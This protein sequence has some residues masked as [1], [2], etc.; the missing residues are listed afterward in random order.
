M[1]GQVVDAKV[2]ARFQPSSALHQPIRPLWH[3]PNRLLDVSRHRLCI[4]FRLGT[5]CRRDIGTIHNGAFLSI[6]TIICHRVV[7]NDRCYG[8][9]LLP[10]LSFLPQR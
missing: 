6:L 4:F 5:L 2:A 8:S 3:F 1:V 9:P 10:V 7:W